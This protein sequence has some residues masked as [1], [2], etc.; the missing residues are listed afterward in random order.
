MPVDRARCLRWTV[1]CEPYARI[2]DSP[3]FPRVLRAQ[4]ARRPPQLLARSRRTIPT[5]L[6][7]NAGMVQFKRIF[8]GQEA[9]RSARARPPRRSACAQAGKHNDLEQVGH[10]AGTT[11]SSRCSAISRSATTSSAMRSALPG[12]SSPRSWDSTKEHLRV[13]VSHDGRR[14]AGALAARSRASRLAHLRAR[15]ARQLLADGGHG[16]VRPVHA[17]STSI[18]RTSRR[19][20]A[21]PAGATGEWTDDRRDGVLARCVRRGR[22]GRALS[23]DLESR[24]HAV[25]PAAGRQLRAAAQAVGRHRRGARAHRGGDAGRDEQLSHGSVRAADREGGG[26][27]S[28]CVQRSSARR[29]GTAAWPRGP[30]SG[31]RPATYDAASFRVL[32]DHARAVAFLLADGVFPVERGTRLRAAPHPASRRAARVAARP[33]RARRSTSS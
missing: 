7:T 23:R 22:G 2:R 13:T 28:A 11:R 10:T 33:P 1:Y 26:R 15:R 21:F 25:R 32:A 31:A 19:D 8:L 24:V 18:S 30:A 9:R 27:W 12:S 14:S 5:L 17:R 4:R 20:W 29:V 3:P 16:T 6:F